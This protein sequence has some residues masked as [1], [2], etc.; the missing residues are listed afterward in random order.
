MF[1]KAK[2]YTKRLLLKN[3][4][5][6]RKRPQI[7]LNRPELALY[8]N[9]ELL[10]KAA[11]YDHHELF[12][13]QVGAYD[14]TSFDPVH[15]II[16]RYPIHA[17]LVEPNRAVFTR[18]QTNYT[19]NSKVLLENIAIAE[20]DGLRDFFV[21]AED[22]ASPDWL[23][24]CSSLQK[25]T[26]LSHKPYFPDV[27]QY[28]RTEKIICMTVASLLS[29]HKIERLDL[30]ILDTEGYDANIIRSID[31]NII[32]PTIIYYEHCHLEQEINSDLMGFLTGFGYSL[33]IDGGNTLAHFTHPGN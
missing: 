21:V 26:I 17:I 27:E 13:L 15:Q 33:H 30:L 20:S 14:G 19:S 3:G 29:R 24:G 28:I 6:V 10:I 5:E 11:L 2:D 32:R 23:E 9:L 8:P 7:L 18:L 1:A 12:L 25:E 4:Y 22:A 31:F 16:Q